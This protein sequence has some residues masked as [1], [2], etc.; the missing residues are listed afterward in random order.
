MQIFLVNAIMQMTRNNV[1]IL[2]CGRL[3]FLRLEKFFLSCLNYN[4]SQSPSQRQW[5]FDENTEECCGWLLVLAKLSCVNH[6]LAPSTLSPR[7]TMTIMPGDEVILSRSLI[8][9]QY[10]SL[11]GAIIG[12]HQAIV[13]VKMYLPVPLCPQ[14]WSTFEPRPP[15]LES[16]AFPAHR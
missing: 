7:V 1:Y 4:R 12:H 2:Y 5:V 13:D 14:T 10:L 8:S 9:N 16:P 11:Q 6:Y 3:R 15:K